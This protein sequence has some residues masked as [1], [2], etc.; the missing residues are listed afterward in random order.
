MSHFTKL[1]GS[2]FPR[3]LQLVEALRRCQIPAEHIHVT[4]DVARRAIAQM[5]PSFEGQSFYSLTNCTRLALPARAR[6]TRFTAE[7][8]EPCHILVTETGMAAFGTAAGGSETGI[9]PPTGATSWCGRQQAQLGFSIDPK[10]GH[11]IPHGDT[12]ETGPQAIAAISTAYT[13]VG[14][15]GYGSYPGDPTKDVQMVNLPDGGF[16]LVIKNRVSAPVAPALRF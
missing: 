9:L 7:Q 15:T 1:N 6:S 2:T 16:R 14:V 5:G 13:L 11:L 3:Y 4:L 8:S 10:T 12:Y